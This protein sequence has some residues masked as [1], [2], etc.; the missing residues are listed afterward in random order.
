MYEITRDEAVE[1]L[2]DVL[3]DRLSI[4]GEWGVGN[5]EKW[6]AENFTPEWWKKMRRYFD[7]EIGEIT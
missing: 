3:F 2:R 7:I 6:V 5:D 4:E 1:I